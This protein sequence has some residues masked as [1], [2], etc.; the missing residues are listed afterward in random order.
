MGE[1]AENLKRVNERIA[2]LVMAFCAEKLKNGC[3]FRMEELTN[4]VKSIMLIA[5]D[6]PGRILRDLRKRGYISY[7]VKSR[8]GSLYRLQSTHMAQPIS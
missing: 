6:S 5:P 4:Y 3:E 8:R 1:Q 2:K 7:T